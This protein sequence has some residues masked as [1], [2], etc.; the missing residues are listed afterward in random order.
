MQKAS[1][2]YSE[3]DPASTLIACLEY[4]DT[5]TAIEK[6]TIGTTRQGQLVLIRRSL[7]K[8]RNQR[9]ISNHPNLYYRPRP[10]IPDYYTRLNRMVQ[11]YRQFSG[12]QTLLKTGCLS[13]RLRQCQHFSA[14]KPH[15]KWRSPIVLHIKLR[16]I[17]L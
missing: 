12:K 1:I 15:D 11:F 14:K 16:I 9:K 4:G 8:R 2:I 13:N 5:I 7:S 10:I 17:L 6:Y 3:P